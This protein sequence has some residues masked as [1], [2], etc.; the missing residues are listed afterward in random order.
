MSKEKSTN[1]ETEKSPVE[2]KCKSFVKHDTGYTLDLNLED[3]KERDKS[4]LS[5]IQMRKAHGT[6]KMKVTITDGD[7]T[8]TAEV[9]VQ[10]HY[11][12]MGFL[13]SN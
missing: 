10:N 6:E 1:A 12:W 9:W 7:K 3:P 8:E 5:L 13:S 2:I 11:P 4:L